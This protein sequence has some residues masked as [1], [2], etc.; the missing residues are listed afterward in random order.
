MLR[1]KAAN[2]WTN[3]E[4]LLPVRGTIM[5][6]KDRVLAEDAPAYTV[7]LNPEVINERGIARR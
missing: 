2:K 5:D 3:E 7:A 1:E 4:M 6:R